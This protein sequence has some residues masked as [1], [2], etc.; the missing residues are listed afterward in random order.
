MPC[1]RGLCL[2]HNILPWCAPFAWSSSFSN[3]FPQETPRLYGNLRP[4]AG[5]MVSHICVHQEPEQDRHH[6]YRRSAH[7]QGAAPMLGP[8]WCR[9][10]PSLR[11]YAYRQRSTARHP[12]HRPQE[13]AALVLLSWLSWSRWRAA[14]ATDKVPPNS[15]FMRASCA[16]AFRPPD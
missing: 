16:A 8:G 5:T 4:P 14:S 12:S 9:S 10:N 3:F 6:P 11:Y 1:F 15:A 2:L 13:F 7:S